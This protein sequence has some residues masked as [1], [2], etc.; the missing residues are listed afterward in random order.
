MV[1]ILHACDASA[2]AYAFCPPPS[3]GPAPAATGAAAAATAL[4]LSLP[5]G[6]A[7]RLAPGSYACLMRVVYENLMERHSTFDAGA[8]PP[9]RP[10]AHNTAFDA[11]PRFGLVLAGLNPYAL[12]TIE[13]GLLQ[14]SVGAFFLS[15]LLGSGITASR[16]PKEW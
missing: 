14:V 15:R 13:T 7:L 2:A 3:P 5:G 6:M 10:P 9:P 8:I 11:A 16:M 4:G 12:M 1:P